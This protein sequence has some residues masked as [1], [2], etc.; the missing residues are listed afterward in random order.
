MAAI[1]LGRA[2]IDSDGVWYDL[3]PAEYYGEGTGTREGVLESVK[4]AAAKVKTSYA[5]LV[6]ESVASTWYNLPVSR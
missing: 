4:A 1:G 6:T 2:I 3:P 5:V